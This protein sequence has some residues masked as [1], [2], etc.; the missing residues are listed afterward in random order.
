MLDRKVIW[1]VVEW[2]PVDHAIYG[3]EGGSSILFRYDPHDGGEG[4]VT[5]LARLC[6]ER[7]YASNRKDIPYSTLA[8]AI[9]KDRKIYYAPAGIDF[10]YEARLEG[11]R[12]IQ[13][14]NSLKIMPYSELIVYDL[15]SRQRT[16]FGPL[17]TRDGRNVY[18]CGGAAAGPDGT[19]YFCCAT[20]AKDPQQA[21]GKVAGNYPFVMELFIY[22]P[23]GR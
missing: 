16:N 18:G 2:D 13:E 7:Y 11:A 10:D 5:E 12:L 23:Q 6:A 19:I 1:R 21:A 15:R 4:K 22:R 8:F 20:E 9:G 17:K 3:V 14:R